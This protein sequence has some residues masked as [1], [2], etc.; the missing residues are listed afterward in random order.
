MKTKAILR[1]L[2]KALPTAT[3]AATTHTFSG[4]ALRP[5]LRTYLVGWWP[6]CWPR[7]RRPHLH[8]QAPCSPRRPVAPPRRPPPPLD[9]HHRGSG[10]GSAAQSAPPRL[11]SPP[12]PQPA[13]SGRPRSV[14][15]SGPCPNW[16]G[17][18]INP[19]SSCL[20][21]SFF[22]PSM[23]TKTTQCS[24]TT[25]EYPLISRTKRRAAN[26]AQARGVPIPYRITISDPL[27]HLECGTSTMYDYES[28]IPTRITISSIDRLPHPEAR[29]S[30]LIRRPEQARL[31]P[32]PTRI[33][34]PL[35]PLPHLEAGLVTEL[36]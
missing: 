20:V 1:K 33:T 21:T 19:S 26:L 4:V 17:R 9:P 35:D 36:A 6:G 3:V 14:F 13:R 23:A 2:T 5:P 11:R 10:S 27:P 34:I 8:R 18:P 25:R 30:T 12:P 31:V 32:S 24:S 16:A 7:C 29:T 22:S 28:P 15:Q